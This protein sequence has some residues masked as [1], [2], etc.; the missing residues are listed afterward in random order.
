M[1]FLRSVTLAAVGAGLCAL[2][3]AAPAAAAPST[4]DK[5]FMTADAQANLAEISLAKLALQRTQTID[6]RNLATTLLTDH[7]KAQTQLADTAQAVG[8]T[9]PTTPNAAQLT[10][11]RELKV[12]PTLDFN[13][14]W[15]GA[16][17]SGHKLAIKNAQTEIRKGTDPRVIAYAKT[18]LAMVQTHLGLVNETIQ[19][20]HADVPVATPP[21]AL[22]T[23]ASPVVSTGPLANGAKTSGSSDVGWLIGLLVVVL[24]GGAALVLRLM[25]SASAAKR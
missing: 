21:P 20:T 14:A 9:L 7:Q 8:F 25:K 15:L 13:K 18:A 22:S 2:I 3:T 24:L 10:D 16:E 6:V 19:G 23:P 17:V 5:T 12:V 4:Q 11:A 1:P